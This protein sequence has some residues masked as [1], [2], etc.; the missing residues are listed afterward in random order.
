MHTERSIVLVSFFLLLLV[1][2]DFLH[3]Q[4]MVAVLLFALLLQ[5]FS[6]DEVGFMRSIYTY[7]IINGRRTVC[8]LRR[9]KAPMSRSNKYY[10]AWIWYI[11]LYGNHFSLSTS[12]SHSHFEHCDF[13]F[14]AHSAVGEDRSQHKTW[15]NWHPFSWI[16]GK[17]Q[18]KIIVIIDSTD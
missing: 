7:K 2:F 17:Y 4:L 9:W 6:P 15:K 10:M 3:F 5:R 18:L 1:S 11:T 13:Y 8:G 14:A 12:R 16:I